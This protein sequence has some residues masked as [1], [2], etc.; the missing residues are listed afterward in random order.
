MGNLRRGAL[1]LTLPVLLAGACAPISGCGGSAAA[2]TSAT[3]TYTVGG[4]VSGLGAGTQLALL[5]NGQDAL[6]VSSSGAFTFPTR[7]AAGSRYA[8]A[9]QRQPS[10]FSCAVSNGSGIVGAAPVAS[11][12]VACGPSVFTVGGVVS[13][14]SGSGLVLADGSTVVA[15]SATAA[16]FRL[17]GSFASGASYDVI[18]KAHPPGHSCSVTHGSGVVGSANVGNIVVACVPGAESVLHVFP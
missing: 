17:P 16:G 2:A 1:R 7:L 8:V 6:M 9:V 15:V 11:V 5:D 18:V 10:G 12:R 13:G 14:L 4:T 3:V